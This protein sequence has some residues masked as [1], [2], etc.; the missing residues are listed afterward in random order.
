MTLSSLFAQNSDL[1]FRS[2]T[3]AEIRISID[4]AKLDWVYANV[5]SDSLHMCSITFQNENLDIVMDSVGFRLRG[6]TSRNAEKKS[7]KLDFNEFVKGQDINGIEKLNLKAEQNDPSLIRS[8]L[9]FGLMEKIGLEASRVAY[10]KVY[11]N[12]DYMGL[13]EIIEHIDENFASYHFGNNNG[14]L[15]KCLWPADLNYRGENASDYYP[16]SGSERPYELKTNVDAFD[17]SELAHLIDVINNTGSFLLKDSLESA[18]RLTDFIKYLAVNIM[19]GSWDD[20]RYLRNNYYLYHDPIIDQFRFIPYDYDNTFGIDWV[21]GSSWGDPNWARINM[22]SYAVMDGDG[23]PLSELIFNDNEYRNLFTHFIDFYTNRVFR[24][25]QWRSYA[26]SIKAR[27]RPDVVLDTYYPLDHGF[28]MTVF[29]DSYDKD[30]RFGHVERGLYEFMRK[31]R[32]STNDQINWRTEPPSIYHQELLQTGDDVRINASVFGHSGISSASVKTFSDNYA[33]NTTYSMNRNRIP[34][35]S[36]IEEFDQW[37]VDL[38]LNSNDK[39]Y[40]IIANDSLGAQR[41]WPRHGYAQFENESSSELPLFINE[42]MASND[43]TIADPAGEYDDWLEIYNASQ[44][45]IDLS[46]MFLSDNPDNLDKWD[47]PI[48]TNIDAGGFLIIWCDEDGDKPQDG[49][50]ANFKL[51]AG[52]EFIALVDADS[53]SVIDHISFGAQIADISYGRSS[54]GGNTW[55]AFSYPTPG[56]SNLGTAVDPLIPL[57]TALYPNYPNPFNPQTTISYSLSVTS[58]VEL[59]IYDLSGR[60][61]ETLFNGIQYTGTY[62]LI[63]NANEHASGVYLAVL[64]I[65]NKVFETKKMVYIK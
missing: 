9:S 62:R 46:G 64:S 59:D 37:S 65:D 38:T 48:G 30:I 21:G 35:T 49:L 12:N 4:Q 36:L 5:D 8:K 60:K 17:Y 39:Y 47:F 13:Y 52:G 50:H 55:I 6:N 45:A 40:V 11:I 18:L 14:N 61:V 19:T 24:E 57:T 34:G 16:Y 44:Y 63:W 41:T 51:S 10:T 15:W 7:F 54:D 58:N 20:Y 43:A 27:I 2:N 26:D 23:R 1:I 32:E 25:D 56:Y 3:V 22:Y 42:F 53:I 33:L 31:R 28:N 29:D